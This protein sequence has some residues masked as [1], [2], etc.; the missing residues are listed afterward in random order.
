MGI[1]RS[2]AQ[3]TSANN[4]PSVEPALPNDGDIVAAL[5]DGATTLKRF[6]QPYHNLATLYLDQNQHKKATLYLITYVK[7]E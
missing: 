5:I 3:K 1:S 6:A 4:N 7:S 2:S